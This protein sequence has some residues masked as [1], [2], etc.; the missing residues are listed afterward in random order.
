MGHDILVSI[1]QWWHQGSMG[2]L[3][4][5]VGGSAPP[6]SEDK[7]GQKSAIFGKYFGFCPLRIAFCP[8]MPHKN[9][10]GATTALERI[11]LKSNTVLCV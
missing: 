7:N 3:P 4:L 9:I 5:P 11:I 2:D 6:P 10:F 8:L 1:E